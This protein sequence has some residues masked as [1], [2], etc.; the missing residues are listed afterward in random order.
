[1]ERKSIKGLAASIT[2]TMLLLC[3][4]I[5]LIGPYV[6][7]FWFEYQSN[8]KII[9]FTQAPINIDDTGKASSEE[10]SEN[11]QCSEENDEIKLLHDAMADYNTKLYADG[12]AEISDINSFQKLPQALEPLENKMIGYIEIPS[13][14]VKLPLYVGASAVNLEKG[15]AVLANT[16]MPVGGMHT[17]CVI[18]GHRGYYSSAY[19]RDIENIHIGD[20]I[21]VT[22]MWETLIYS[23]V[24]V[25]IIE[26]NDIEA[27]KIQEGKDLVTLLTCHPYGG[28]GKYR[29]LV[30]CERQDTGDETEASCETESDNLTNTESK[31]DTLAETSRNI[32][33]DKTVKNGSGNKSVKS[34]KTDIM[35]EHLLRIAGVLLLLY[36]IVNNTSKN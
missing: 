16:S 29:Y 32:R 12:Q 3:G 18:A 21:Y 8:V 23:A 35:L 25:Q 1:M 2:R 26:P 4:I 15:A 19:F 33:H 22:N 14:N 28:N 9:N 17:N 6:R 24:K 10:I 34:S 13:I 11:I 27:I 20:K 7:N 36:A 30:F 31:I 5:L